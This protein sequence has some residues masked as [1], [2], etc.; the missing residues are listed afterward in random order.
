MRILLVDDDAMLADAVARAFTQA[1]HAV[2]VVSSGVDA[3]QR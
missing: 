2:D 1:A 3:D